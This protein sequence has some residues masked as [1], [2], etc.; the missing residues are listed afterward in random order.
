MNGYARII[1]SINGDKLRNI[2][3]I[4]FN[5][6][7]YKIKTLV[8]ILND[9][10]IESFHVFDIKKS[11]LQFLYGLFVGLGYINTIVQW[12]NTKTYIAEHI[13]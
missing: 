6:K 3:N 4:F 12:C 9:C 10:S 1:C 7:K 8:E 2:E 11:D 13:K 5:V